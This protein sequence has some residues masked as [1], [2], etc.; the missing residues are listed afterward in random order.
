MLPRWHYYIGPTSARLSSTGRRSPDQY[1]NYIIGHDNLLSFQLMY[2]FAYTSVFWLNLI[3]KSPAYK[4]MSVARLSWHAA[5][6]YVDEALQLSKL[7]TTCVSINIGV[8]ST[9]DINLYKPTY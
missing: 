2:H 1:G 5:S 3:I 9:N 8:L 7:Y 6:Q 4:I